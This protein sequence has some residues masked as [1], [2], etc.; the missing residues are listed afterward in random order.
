M[1][2]TS[3]ESEGLPAVDRLR[4]SKTE[5]G[6]AQK[7]YDSDDHDTDSSASNSDDEEDSREQQLADQLK[8]AVRDIIDSKINFANHDSIEPWLKKYDGILE[9]QADHKGNIMHQTIDEARDKNENVESALEVL[10]TRYP[11]L[12]DENQTRDTNRTPIFLAVSQGKSRMISALIRGLQASSPTPQDVMKSVSE[13][14]VEGE[15]CLHLAIKTKLKESAIRNLLSIAPPEVLGLR[16]NDGRTP[17]HHVVKYHDCGIHKRLETVREML[18]MATSGSLAKKDNSGNSLFL[19][20]LETSEQFKY[21]LAEQKRNEAESRVDKDN[22]I[23]QDIKTESFKLGDRPVE[24]D[25]IRPSGQLDDVK[26]T[27]KQQPR[28]TKSDPKTEASKRDYRSGSKRGAEAVKTAEKEVRFNTATIS[29]AGDVSERLVRSNQG[30]PREP[31]LHLL[32]TYDTEPRNTSRRSSP[33][34]TRGQDCEKD[35]ERKKIEKRRELLNRKEEETLPPK[36][37]KDKSRE[38]KRES[39]NRREADRMSSDRLSERSEKIKQEIKL[40]C[41]RKMSPMETSEVIYGENPTGEYI[42]KFRAQEHH[43]TYS[44]DIQIYFDF[45]FSPTAVKLRT[46]KTNFS[47]ATFDPYLQYV[48]FPSVTIEQEHDSRLHSTSYNSVGAGKR[49][50]TPRQ[51]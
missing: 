25:G 23:R 48:A 22:P 12:L 18:R 40:S 46:F 38:S 19:Y 7:K 32:S 16:D 14:R 6:P 29:S 31:S 47:H 51:T 15:T 8:E 41:M 2:I 27:E 5:E 3:Q 17:L 42:Q 4:Q 36:A 13:K 28:L 39:K 50:R 24:M 49:V 45:P 35:E 26:S 44:A 34:G 43:S 11:R 33:K 30:V 21:D 1:D 10:A 37:R 9:R 20:H